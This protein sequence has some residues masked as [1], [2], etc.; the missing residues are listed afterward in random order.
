LAYAGKY[1]T[2][3][4]SNAG[5]L[6]AQ[7]GTYPNGVGGIII[8]SRAGAMGHAFNWFVENGVVHVIDAG[9]EI[10]DLAAYASSQGFSK[11]TWI[12]TL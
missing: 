6:V 10:K 7:L 11:L 9:A 3:T 4:A 2:V 12:S 5:Q 1:G 8:G